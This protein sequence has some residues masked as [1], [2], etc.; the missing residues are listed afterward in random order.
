M[1]GDPI[2]QLPAF[3]EDAAEWQREFDQDPDA[4]LERLDREIERAE[5]AGHALL[6]QWLQEVGRVNGWL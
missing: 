1:S 4:T 6:G 2:T 3:Q 5:E